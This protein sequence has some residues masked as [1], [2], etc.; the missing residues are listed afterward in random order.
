MPP[1]IKEQAPPVSTGPKGILPEYDY[2]KNGG[3]SLQNTPLDPFLPNNSLLG[4]NAE[5]NTP[6]CIVPNNLPRA[7]PETQIPKINT[8]H[9][10]KTKMTGE[11]TYQ[12]T[13][14]TGPNLEIDDPD[15]VD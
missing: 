9:H 8:V 4:T 10:I 14:G 1:E 5:P 3:S 2:A 13:N 11:P 15:S 7:K 12:G 6:V